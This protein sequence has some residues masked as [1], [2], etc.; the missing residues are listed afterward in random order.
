[1]THTGS[2]GHGAHDGPA[3]F[4]AAEVESFHA[5]DRQATR[6]IIG[7]MGGIFTIGLLLY[8]T[9]CYLVHIGW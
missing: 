7:L 1:M 6:N 2:P 9:V 4:P 5:A 8:A 3:P